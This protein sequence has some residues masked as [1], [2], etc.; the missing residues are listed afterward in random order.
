VKLEK[1]YQRLP[2]M[3]QKVELVVKRRNVKIP[4]T[5]INAL[6]CQYAE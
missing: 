5:R 1:K 4:V 6:N 2:V 3:A